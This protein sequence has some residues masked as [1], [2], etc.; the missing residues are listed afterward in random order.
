M[1]GANRRDGN[2]RGTSVTHKAPNPK[3]KHRVTPTIPPPSL[4]MVKGRRYG[5]KK[6]SNADNKWKEY[7]LSL[8]RGGGIGKDEVEEDRLVKEKAPGR[9]R[10]ER[11][12]SGVG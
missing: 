3:D 6:N 5:T 7:L 12:R 2:C 4:M 1:S 9:Q 11:W 8:G 10:K